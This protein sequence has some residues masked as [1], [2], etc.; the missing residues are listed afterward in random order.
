MGQKSLRSPLCGYLRHLQCHTAPTH[1]STKAD[2]EGILLITHQDES[3]GTY[4]GQC[5]RE[6]GIF[7]W[8]RY[9]KV[10]GLATENAVVV[11]CVDLQ[12]LQ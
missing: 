10:G 3:I 6:I 8:V 1:Q 4:G 5:R 2:Y 11:R 9:R 7:L 12:Y